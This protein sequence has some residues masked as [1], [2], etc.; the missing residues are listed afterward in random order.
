MKWLAIFLAA[1]PAAAQDL[2]LP[3]NAVEQYS[4]SQAQGQYLLPTGPYAGTVLPTQSIDGPVTH[5][6]WRITGAGLTTLQLIA[7][8]QEQL[9]AQGFEIL[10]SCD[11]QACGGFDFRF[12]TE[13]L[14]PPLMYV[15]LGNFRFLSAKRDDASEA[16]AILASRSSRAGFIQ[17]I[18]VGT[19]P[20]T[21][22]TTAQLRPARPQIPLGDFGQTLEAS[23]HFVLADLRFEIG[24]STLSDGPFESLQRLAEYLSTNPDRTVAL[25]GHTDAQ[26]SLDGNIALSRRR[27]AAVLE[28]LV[29][30]HG[31]PRRQLE[32]QGMGYLS[33]LAT[34]LTE[35][36]R[37]ANRRVEVI[38]TNTP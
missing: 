33:P 4:A 14:P 36:G 6:S 38:V 10:L 7:P 15:D 3:S 32:A 5:Q 19:E 26:G 2:A 31:V 21:A 35:E 13:V 12:A 29:S 8:L 28:R 22:Q 18:T 23:G 27:A 9:M 17:I 11:T 34:N 25:V 20:Q 1:S 30:V 16:V 24:S 37:D